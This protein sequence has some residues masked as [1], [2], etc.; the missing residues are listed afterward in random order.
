MA[1]LT[2][3]E[4]MLRVVAIMIAVSFLSMTLLSFL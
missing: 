4:M 3:R 2:R 1:R